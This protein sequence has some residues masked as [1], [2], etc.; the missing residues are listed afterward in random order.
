MPSRATIVVGNFFFSVCGALTL[1]I[2]LPYLTTFMPET[3]TGLAIALGGLFALILFPSLPPL[4][5]RYGA[6]RF[7]LVCAVAEMLALFALATM[8]GVI[9][10]IV[11]IIV[12]ISLQSFLSYALDLLFEASL[13]KRST[14]GEGRA[15]FLTMANIGTLAAL[16][17]I[18]KLL[19]NANAYGSA[20]LVAAAALVPVLV[21]FAARELPR[22][23]PPKIS[24]L[25]DSLL[26]IAL[27]RDFSAVTFGHFVLYLFYM[28]VSLYI[29]FYLHSIL[30]L[31]WSVLG[32]LLALM[33]IPHILLEY[34]AG[35]IADRFLGDK[36][37]M[38]AG[39]L[40]AGA[41]LAALSFLTPAASPLL[42]LGILV[43]ARAGTA[44]IESMTEA[45]FFRRVTDQDINSMSVFR[46][47][48]PL[49]YIVAPLV[50]SVILSF[51]D[52][53]IF[54]IVTGAFIA[55][56]GGI[57]TLLVRDVR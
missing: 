50:G 41:G 53:H 17:L 3:Y 57:A 18:G 24:H 21:L 29:P 13:T 14:A 39:F 48:S 45:H 49:A 37:L 5:A 55:I 25:R 52:Y 32:W 11:F 8:P 31:S 20:F 33:L 23:T 30:G 22:G 27:D 12:T 7:F 54:F 26:A 2:F 19:G 4:V 43:I 9:A 36:M 15:A 46:G 1:Y 16:L 56:A 35:W 28:W 34:P 51:G 42:I 47:M 44:L 38:F 10:S 6:Q 40:A